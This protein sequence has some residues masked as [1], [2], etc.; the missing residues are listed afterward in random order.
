MF[1]LMFFS[2]LL[3]VSLVSV[4]MVQPISLMLV[5]M[6]FSMI[7]CFFSGFIVSSMMGFLVFMIYVGGVMIIF[8]YVLSVFPNESVKVKGNFLL[9]GVLN[10][11]ILCI[12][13]SLDTNL[14]DMFDAL[15]FLQFHYM[16]VSLFCGLFLFMVIFLFFIMVCVSYFCM[17]KRLPLRALF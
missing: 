7:I 12:I 14:M 11:F 17:K 10:C 3:S 1:I 8:I 5:L 2:C 9:L 4:W 15:S 16:S 6:F 13:S